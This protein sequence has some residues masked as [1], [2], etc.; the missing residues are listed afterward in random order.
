MD[1]LS[2]IEYVDA[3]IKENEEFIKENGLL[4]EVCYNEHIFIR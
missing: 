4:K 1:I 3:L 2:R